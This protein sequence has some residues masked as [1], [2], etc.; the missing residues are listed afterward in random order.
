MN[1]YD[2]LGRIVA[3]GALAVLGGGAA[4]LCVSGVLGKGLCSRRLEPREWA[5]FV[6]ATGIPAITFILIAVNVLTGRC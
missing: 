6:L 1:G 4:A 3:A 2:I 5:W